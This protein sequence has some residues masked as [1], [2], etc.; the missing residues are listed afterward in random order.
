MFGGQEAVLYSFTSSSKEFLYAILFSYASTVWL[1]VCI[2]Q[3]FS[4]RDPAKLVRKSMPIGCSGWLTPWLWQPSLYWL[5]QTCHGKS[6]P[7]GPGFLS[8][9][10]WYRSVAL[11]ADWVCYFGALRLVVWSYGWRSFGLNVARAQD[12]H[13]YLTLPPFRRLL[14]LPPCRDTSDSQGSGCLR[15]V[16]EQFSVCGSFFMVL[17]AL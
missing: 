10:T 4:R 15:L 3:L 5:E 6:F 16:W 13:G 14:F 2:S 8:S 9:L 11:F 1:H 12:V 7:K 17:V